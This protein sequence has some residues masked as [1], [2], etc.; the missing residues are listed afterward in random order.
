MDK[1]QCLIKLTEEAIQHLEAD[2]HNVKTDT[3]R[4][5]IADAISEYKKELTVLNGE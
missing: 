1:K 3:G 4:T 5:I 2:F